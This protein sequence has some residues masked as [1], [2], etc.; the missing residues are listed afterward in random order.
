MQTWIVAF[1]TFVAARHG[2]ATPLSALAVSVLVSLMAFPASIIGNELA[3]RFG[4]HRAIAL[5]MAASAVTALGIGLAAGASP[6]LLVALLAVYSFTVPADSGALTSGMTASAYEGQRGA[7]MA[8]HSTVG[9]GLSALGAWGM[10]YAIDVAGGP[11]TE[12]AWLA[13]FTLLA[14]SISAGPVALWW[15]RRA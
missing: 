9:F 15:A 5:T 10:G 3:L 2:Q 6:W 14:L 7:T 8:L 1:W 11:H 4:R 13:G 12:Q